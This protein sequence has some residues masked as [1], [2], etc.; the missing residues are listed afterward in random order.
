MEEHHPPVVPRRRPRRR[1]ARAALAG[2][3]RAIR[4][5]TS[6]PSGDQRDE[7]GVE[8]AGV[9]AS[10]GHGRASPPQ[11]HQLRAEAR[12]HGQQ[13]P[14]LPG[15]GRWSARVSSRTRSTE[16]EERLPTSRR[17]LQVT[18]SAPGASSSDSCMASS[19]LGPPGWQTQEAMSARVRPWSARKASTSGRSFSRATT[20]HVGRE[21]DLEAGL[22]DVPAHHPLGVRVEDRAGGDDRAARPARGRSLPGHHDG[23]GAVAE[24]ARRR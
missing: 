9:E 19:T 18:S 23:G 15:G 7:E 22:G 4:S 8:D 14:Q 13:Q 2:C 21:D 1:P 5:S 16:V 11:Q 24:E 3:A 12:A 10:E 20:G 17:L 6:R